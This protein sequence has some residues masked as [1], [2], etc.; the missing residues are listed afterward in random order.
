MANGLVLDLVSIFLVLSLAAEAG[1]KAA[2]QEPVSKTG[3]TTATEILGISIPDPALAALIGAAVAGSFSVLSFFLVKRKEDT[4]RREQAELQHLQRQIEEL[5][6][7]LLGHLQ[8]TQVVYEIAMARLRRT[9]GSMNFGDLSEDEK[10]LWLFLNN[11][12]LLPTNAEVAKLLQAKSFLL[13]SLDPPQSIS[14]FGAHAIQY[15]LVNTVWQETG[16][17]ASFINHV[18]FPKDLEEYVRTTLTDLRSRHNHYL[19]RLGAKTSFMNS[20]QRS[21]EAPN[22]AN[23]ADG[24]RKQRGSRRSSA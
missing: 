4:T 22:P 10:R 5:Y 6:G 21:R 11:T 18:R 14:Q 13:D 23:R 19:R 24:N 2:P 15:E 20:V 9:D 1:P 16:V 8:T 12:Y 17:D 3:H 7:P